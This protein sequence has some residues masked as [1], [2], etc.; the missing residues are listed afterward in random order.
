MGIINNKTDRIL[1]ELRHRYSNGI[2]TKYQYDLLVEKCKKEYDYFDNTYFENFDEVIKKHEE[3]IDILDF[4]FNYF[5]ESDDNGEKKVSIINRIIHK[6]N[7]FI[8]NCKQKIMSF[9]NKLKGDKYDSLNGISVEVNTHEKELKMLEDE[10]RQIED[11]IKRTKSGKAD[12]SRV[13]KLKKI[14]DNNKKKIAIGVVT[15]VTIFKFISL[16][17][18]GKVLKDYKNWEKQNDIGSNETYNLNLLQEL[19]LML[20]NNAIRTMK[21]NMENKDT[22]DRISVVANL[23]H[24]WGALLLP[25]VD[26]QKNAINQAYEHEFRKMSNEKNKKRIDALRVDEAHNNY[27]EWDNKIDKVIT[28]YLKKEITTKEMKDEIEKIDKEY[29][30]KKEKL[31][32]IRNSQETQKTLDKIEKDYDKN[33]DNLEK[34]FRIRR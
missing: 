5:I 24:G 25:G 6:I 15:T 14:V 27:K 31:E 29:K 7:E 22:I 26:F 3:S 32:S 34:I 19:Y 20:D 23:K 4:K 8:N 2:I 13:Q 10:R 16:V 30:E 21:I 33:V 11:E 28:K 12:E 17:N 1:T 18:H 9:I